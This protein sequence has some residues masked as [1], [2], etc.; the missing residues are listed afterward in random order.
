MVAA[1]CDKNNANYNQVGTFTKHVDLST[2]RSKFEI[3]L[4]VEPKKQLFAPRHLQ[5]VVE[6][7]MKATNKP[8]I[9]HNT[10]TTCFGIC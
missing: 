3:P 9:N 7:D 5:A 10:A 8:K 6:L 2:V 1:E 4:K